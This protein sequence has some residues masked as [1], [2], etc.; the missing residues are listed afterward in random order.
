MAGERTKM[1]EGAGADVEERGTYTMFDE[2]GDPGVSACLTCVVCVMQP[3][4]VFVLN[5]APTMR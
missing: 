1:P 3:P 5:V 2:Y 4:A